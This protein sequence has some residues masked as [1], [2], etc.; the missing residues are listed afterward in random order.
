MPVLSIDVAGHRAIIKGRMVDIPPT[1][2][3]LFRL[4]M[5][6]RGQV[7]PMRTIMDK[8]WGQETDPH[9]VYVNICKL[10]KKLG[11]YGGRIKAVKP[12]G[13]YKY[14]G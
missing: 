7:I 11:P 3:K 12:H 1:E 8:I 9:Y 2:F 13:F 14:E 6:N 10:R 4:F 5:F